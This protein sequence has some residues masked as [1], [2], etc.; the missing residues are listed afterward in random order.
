MPVSRNIR[1]GAPDDLS[2]VVRRLLMINIIIFV[3]EVV[4]APPLQHH[5]L[6]LLGLSIAGLRMRAYWQ[7]FTYMFLHGGTAH[8]LMNMLALYL[9]GPTVERRLGARLFLRLYLLSGILGGIGFLIVDP[10][11]VCIGASGA[12]FGVFGAFVALYP[13]EQL[14]LLFLPF[15]RFQAWVFAVIFIGIELM[16]LIGGR[17][18]NIAHSAHI[19]G[20]IAGFVIARVLDRRA[21]AM[22][23]ADRPLRAWI[24]SASP[25]PLPHDP[26]AAEVD[27]ILD[28]VATEGIGALTQAERR[29]LEFSSRRRNPR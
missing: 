24:R 10:R 5:L 26:D 7:L 21:R 25:P 1:A 3:L 9:I 18:G 15:I 13:R 11:G 17:E 22:E 27:R 4:V 16:I 29:V 14:E 28:K 20:A 12:V 23:I 6:S 2:P 8:L 19:A